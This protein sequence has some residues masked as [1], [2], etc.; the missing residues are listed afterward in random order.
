MDLAVNAPNLFDCRPVVAS[1]RAR[2][3][4]HRLDGDVRD[5]RASSMPWISGRRSRDAVL[6]IIQSL[7][8]RI[9]KAVV[10]DLDNTLWG[11]VVGDDGLENIQ[12]GDLGIGKAFSDLQAWLKQLKQRGIL[13]AVCSKNYEHV[14]R[15]VFE[16]H[17]DM[18]LRLDDIAVFVANWE[19]KVD[20][21]RHIQSRSEHR[22]R[23]HGLPR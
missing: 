19:N 18:V 2:Q 13:L 1:E 16:N 20:N 5:D 12:I 14:A 4:Q 21:I 6:D 17:P 23:Q 10:L 22:L 3:E 7:R 9:H 8:G 11:G 15:E